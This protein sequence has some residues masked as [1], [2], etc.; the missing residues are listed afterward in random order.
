MK[1]SSIPKLRKG[2]MKRWPSRKTRSECH[3]KNLNENR[4]QGCIA[5]RAKLL[6]LITIDNPTEHA[7]F[8]D[9]AH[10]QRSLD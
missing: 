4:N 10:L 9:T 7:D 5:N 2:R 1:Q 8:S 3:C 6:L